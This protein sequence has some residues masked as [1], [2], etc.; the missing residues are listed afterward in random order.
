MTSRGITMRLTV[1]DD[2]PG[3]KIYPGRERITVY[4]DD[5]EVSR[6]LTADDEKGEVIVIATTNDGQPLIEDGELVHKTLH[7]KVRIERHGGY[8]ATR[9]QNTVVGEALYQDTHIILP[10]HTTR[11]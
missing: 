2:D 8:L 4:L 6:C 3:I 1:L 5:V 7:G 11:T 10:N 9:N